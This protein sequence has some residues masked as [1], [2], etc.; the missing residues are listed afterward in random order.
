M[1]AR[2]IATND[3]EGCLLKARNSNDESASSLWIFSR[4]ADP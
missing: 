1:L 4:S 3:P 2:P